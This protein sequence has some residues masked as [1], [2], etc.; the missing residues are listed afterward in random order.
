MDGAI[1]QVR[2]LSAPA[3]TMVKFIDYARDVSHPRSPV[4]RCDRNCRAPS[5]QTPESP[6]SEQTRSSRAVRQR[7]RSP[8]FK[9]QLR[10]GRQYEANHGPPGSTYPDRW[11]L[12]FIVVIVVGHFLGERVVSLSG[13]RRPKKGSG[14]FILVTEAVNESVKFRLRE[15]RR[16][17]FE[18][19]V[20]CADSRDTRAAGSTSESLVHRLPSFVPSVA[21]LLV[22]LVPCSRRALSSLPN[23]SVAVERKATMTSVS[24]N[25]QFTIEAELDPRCIPESLNLDR[26]GET[27]NA[28][29]G[30]VAND[31]AE[32]RFSP[33]T[34]KLLAKALSR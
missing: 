29:A 20:W 19:C 3:H 26:L 18:R 21:T 27:L 1:K 14:D 16:F 7:V 17:E 11:T 8:S 9:P 22:A 12:V 32:Q 24:S 13:S 6:S 25:Q 23:P 10:T 4:V 2:V 30:T 33:R 34:S 31:E 15:E 5:R 28:F